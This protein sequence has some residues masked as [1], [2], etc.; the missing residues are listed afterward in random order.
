MHSLQTSKGRGPCP[1]L[2]LR[3]GGA[4]LR[5]P[6]ARPALMPVYAEPCVAQ[7]PCTPPLATLTSVGADAHETVVG[8]PIHM[9]I[10]VLHATAREHTN[11]VAPPG[12]KR[13]AAFSWQYPPIVA[14]WLHRAR[15]NRD[16]VIVGQGRAKQEQRNDPDDRIAFGNVSIGPGRRN[17][18]QRKRRREDASGKRF[19]QRSCKHLLILFS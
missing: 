3:L 8:Q 14:R 16:V 17:T 13:A 1:S 7:A 11:T 15:F 5:P 10:V 12:L 6:N 18:C 4:A 2:C 9:T 19:G